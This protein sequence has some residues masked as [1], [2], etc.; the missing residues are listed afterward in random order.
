M[1]NL[2]SMTLHERMITIV[3]AE[4]SLNYGINDLTFQEAC[5]KWLIET[6]TVN[7]VD[8]SGIS[9]NKYSPEEA[10]SIIRHKLDLRS[11]NLTELIHELGPYY[12]IHKYTAQEALNKK[13]AVLVPYSLS[14]DGVNDRVACGNDASLQIA[15]DITYSCWFLTSSTATPLSLIEKF[16]SNTG[17]FVFLSGGKTR[18]WIGNGSAIVNYENFGADLR[19]GT[20]HHLVVVNDEDVGTFVYVDGVSQTT[21]SMN[22][23]ATNMA[24]NT[25]RELYIGTYSTTSWPFNGK[26][27]EV[28]V[29]NKALTQAEVTSL[30][31]A[32]PQ[33]AGDAVGLTNLVGYWK[34]DHG[35][36]PVARDVSVAEILGTTPL[37]NSD[38]SSGDFTGWTLGGPPDASEVISHDGHETAAHITTSSSNNGPY[39][40]V[41]TSGL[42][43][44]VSFDVKVISGDVY[45]GKS[46]NKVGGGNFTDSSW[47]SYTYYWIAGDTTFRAY[48]A[49]A[50]SEFYID[51]ISVKEVTNGNHGTINGATWTV[52]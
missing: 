51:N 34:M 14:F 21:G 19:D 31:A 5:N 47:T 42:I 32:N 52:H 20:W 4:H 22:T 37:S 36:G 45:L 25:D 3:N 1:A 48:N 24:P 49:T 30:Y 46:D 2:Q 12:P 27:D 17:M 7:G 39:Q 29:F 44:K 13:N 18:I 40:T 50:S 23:T 10:F 15:G 43:Y 26:I 16:G 41:I 33:N 38:F 28:S 35:S 8:Y 6:G 9:I 11:E